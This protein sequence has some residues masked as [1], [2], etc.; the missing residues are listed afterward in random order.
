LSGH[1]PRRLS[2]SAMERQLY[3]ARHRSES[4]RRRRS[5]QSDSGHSTRRWPADQQ[6]RLQILCRTR[7]HPAATDSATVLRTEPLPPRP[8]RDSELESGLH[9]SFVSRGHAE[10]G[11]ALSR[12]ALAVDH[13]GEWKYARWQRHLRLQPLAFHVRT[14]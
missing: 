13:G 2:D 6:K 7:H 3:R 5:E 12:S 9:V 11:R 14:G 4:E 8:E 10:P 1:V